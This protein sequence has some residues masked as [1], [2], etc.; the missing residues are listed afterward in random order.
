MTASVSPSI[1]HLELTWRSISDLCDGL[2]EQEWKRPTGCPGWT[3]QDNV[4]HLVDYEAAALGRPAPDHAPPHVEHTKNALGQSNEIGVDHRRDR[5]GREV[6][7]ELRAVTAERLEQ[8]RGLTREDL[9]KEVTTP[10]GPGTVADMLT[11]RVMD[12][13]SHEQ[14]IRRALDRPGHVAGPAAEEA[15]SYFCRFLPFVVGKRAGAPDGSSVVVEVGDLRREVI[16]VVDGRA[17]TSDG[18]PAT[19]TVTLSMP[20]A[21]FAA[22]VGGRSDAPDDVTITGDEALGRAVVDA[23][24]FMP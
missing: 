11:L 3:V 10:A 9:A 1:D 6:L 2:S 8:L 5:T 14:D 20:V 18:E 4:S 12:T 21:T 17:R 13:W 16:E 19:P 22:L 7:D 24:G 23:L 15:V